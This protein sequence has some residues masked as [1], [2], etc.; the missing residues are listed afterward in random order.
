MLP[1]FLQR[2]LFLPFPHPRF[3][4][5]G[6]T[7]KLYDEVLHI[8]IEKDLMNMPQVVASHNL[9]SVTIQEVDESLPI[10]RTG[11][12]EY[13]D[14]GGALFSQSYDSESNTHHHPSIPIPAAAAGDSVVH[15]H[16]SGISNQR[17]VFVFGFGAVVFWGFPRG[18]VLSLFG[19][20]LLFV[21]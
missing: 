20:V 13:V 3:L 14:P 18:E 7:C 21:A 17:E 15:H 16:Q 12:S 8:C 19:F 5:N 2:K 11:Y 6:I 10:S 1:P 4:G 9:D